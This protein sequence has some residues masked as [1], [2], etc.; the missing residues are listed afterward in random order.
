MIAESESKYI[1]LKDGNWIDI[2]PDWSNESI[3]FDKCVCFSPT[4]PDFDDYTPMALVLWIQKHL[5]GDC[6]GNY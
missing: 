4:N 5:K 2:N 1:L 3:R 6:Y